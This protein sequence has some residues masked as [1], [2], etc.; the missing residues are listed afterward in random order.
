MCVHMCAGMRADLE[1]EGADDGTEPHGRRHNE[2]RHVTRTALLKLAQPRE[3][4]A[5]PWSLSSYG[6]V[7]VRSS[8]GPQVVM[9]P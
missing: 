3:R 9:A 2:C 4:P 6:P 1:D 5:E 7:N 8:H